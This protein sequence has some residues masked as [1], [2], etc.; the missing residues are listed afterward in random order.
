MYNK[1]IA[2]LDYGIGDPSSD[3]RFKLGSKIYASQCIEP[4]NTE[5][6]LGTARFT[7]RVD[8]ALDCEPVDCHSVREIDYS[9]AV[10]NGM[11]AWYRVKTDH[12]SS[13]D[14]PSLTFLEILER[15]EWARQEISIECDVG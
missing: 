5:P 12:S 15:Y 6:K 10:K 8:S 3:R 2:L 13:G 14:I 7:E 4:C 1:W 11:V 9:R